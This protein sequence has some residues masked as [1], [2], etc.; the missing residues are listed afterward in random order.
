[1][2]EAE[3]CHHLAI[4]ETGHLRNQ[5]TPQDLLGQLRNR[6]VAITGD[7]L[8]QVKEQALRLPQVQS[9]AQQGLHL[10]VLLREGTQHPTDYLREQLANPGLSLEQTQPSLEDVFVA[11]TS[12]GNRS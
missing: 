1:M 3:R 8:R 7:N 10:R 12:G 2:D 5:G 11:S 9:A 6:V 4:L